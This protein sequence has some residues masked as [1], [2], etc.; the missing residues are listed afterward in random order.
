MGSIAVVPATTPVIHSGNECPE[1]D[2][3][4]YLLEVLKLPSGV[5][6]T[7]LDED[8]ISRANSLG[9]A[10]STLQKR[11]TSGTRTP[12]LFGSY[13]DRSVSS[14]SSSAAITPHSSVFGASSPVFITSDDNS[15][16]GLNFTQYDEYLASL[17]TGAGHKFRKGSLPVDSSS[18]SMFSVSTKKSFSSVSGTKTT[19]WWKKKSFYGL[20][21]TV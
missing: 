9:I 2:E 5:S 7:H 6:E 1:V 21:S 3:A 13:Q 19:K 11:T 17:D 20:E 4:T 16:S 15:S 8:L 18:H 14:S 12:S 10:A